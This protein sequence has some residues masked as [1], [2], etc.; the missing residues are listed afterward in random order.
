MAGI[1]SGNAQATIVAE[2]GVGVIELNQAVAIGAV[3][4]S[5]C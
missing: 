2:G 3:I 4:A 5:A 1:S